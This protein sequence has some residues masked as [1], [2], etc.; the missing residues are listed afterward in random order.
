MRGLIK[1]FLISGL[2]FLSCA[3][4]LLGQAK[5]TQ[6]I[7]LHVATFDS[8][9]GGFFTAKS[10]EKVT[11]PLLERYDTAITI[12]H[13]GDTLNSPYGEKSPA[14]IA[15][16]GSD[17]V[18]K[19]L[20]EGADMVFIACNTASTQYDKIEQAVDRAYPGRSRDVFSIVDTSAHE[21]KRL[22]DQ[23][24]LQATDVHF[25][26]LATPATVKSMV[27]PRRLA[28]FYGVPLSEQNPHIITQPRW[29]KS[30]GDTVQSITQESV[31]HLPGGKTIH[32]YQM[33]P[34]NWVD[35]IEHG[36]DLKLKNDAVQR[37]LALL[38]ALLP[39]GAR[40]DTVGYF[41]TH[42]PAFDAAIRL[43]MTTQGKA[44][45]NTEYILQGPLMAT[46]FEHEA[47]ARL[48]ENRRLSPISPEELARLVA[49]SRA[50]ITI[51]GDNAEV[52]R[53]LTRTLFPGDPTPIIQVKSFIRAKCPLRQCD[54][55][56][57]LDK[58]PL[59][60]ATKCTPPILCNAY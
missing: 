10:I 56:E 44:D 54:S 40:L 2:L 28:Q 14:E 4:A 32:I 41:C 57:S 23:R 13:Y 6:P 16:L 20:D 55:Q 26:I 24:L 11:P 36:A 58:Q 30:K 50:S 17:G 46:I 19:A 49:L 52:T 27:Y 8:G 35:L 43:E 38:F 12:R 59:A 29:L 9:F 1:R 31:I 22:I 21:A 53:Q 15:K 39:Q 5:S 37:D 48:K 60:Y 18:L 33:A 47:N 7:A 42:Y 25:A 45:L 3:P 34:A 51:S